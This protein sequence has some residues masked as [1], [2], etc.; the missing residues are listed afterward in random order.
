MKTAG[1]YRGTDGL[2]LYELGGCR[3]T[4]G[5]VS[6]AEISSGPGEPGRLL[7]NEEVF[8]DKVVERRDLI[9]ATG[10][11]ISPVLLV[12]DEGEMYGSLLAQAVPAVRPL[13]SEVD[14][15]GITHRIWAL[16]D[17]PAITAAILDELSRHTFLVADGNHRSLAAQQAGF[18]WCLAV[19]ADPA[20]L[21][22]E[23]YDRLLDLDISGAELIER[24][25]VLGP[26]PAIRREPG[27]S[28]LYADHRLL[29]LH[30]PADGDP[31]QRLPH[32]VVEQRLL[33]E[34]L[35]LDPATVTYVGGDAAAGDLIA[36][37]D[38]GEATG[39]LLLRPVTTAEF[40]GVNA[41]RLQMPRKS[42][43][44]TPKAR[45]GLVLAEL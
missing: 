22:I 33:V 20:G 38:R 36:R 15:R 32:A 43:W 35:G 19:V 34:A 41:A 9:R 3:A 25:T 16:A 11:L 40:V 27:R 8:A 13:V 42:T 29:E 37:V 17:D 1:R 12:P 21:R 44:F 26:T 14:E 7:R 6:T 39:A 24:A 45:S 4:V 18:G 28:Y 10:H 23:A 31:V 30:L 5:L 2:F